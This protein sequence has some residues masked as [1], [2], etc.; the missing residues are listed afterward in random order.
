MIYGN[1]NR[2]VIDFEGK[3]FVIDNISGSY[4]HPEN[5]T[6]MQYTGLKDKNGKEIFE[7]DVVQFECTNEKGEERTEVEQVVWAKYDYQL[8]NRKGNA[9]IY[10]IGE[11]VIEIIGNVW[12]N[13]ELLNT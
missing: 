2:A 3:V 10:A 6:L 4:I 11:D 12:E 8:I 5:V 9:P 13:P 1:A 7:G